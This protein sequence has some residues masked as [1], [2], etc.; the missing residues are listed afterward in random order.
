MTDFLTTFQTFQLTH[1]QFGLAQLSFLSRLVQRLLFFSFICGK[2]AS[3][4]LTEECVYIVGDYPCF[5][6]MK[7]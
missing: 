1:T 7:L 5:P 2:F 6:V 3:F 4:I